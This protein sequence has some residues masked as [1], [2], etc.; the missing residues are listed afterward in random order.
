MLTT[1][2]SY[3]MHLLTHSERRAKPIVER[4]QCDICGA[5][6]VTHIITIY[7]YVVYLSLFSRVNRKSSLIVHMARHNEKPIACTICGKNLLNRDS[8]RM[9]NLR[10]HSEKKHSCIVC[11]KIFIQL[12]TLKVSVFYLV[13]LMFCE[14][15]AVFFMFFQDHMSLHTGQPQHKCPYCAKEF[16]SNSN[17]CSH[18]KKMHPIEWLE[19]RMQKRTEIIGIEAKN[20]NI[21]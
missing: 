15:I 9:H 13:F 14:L 7:Q 20:Q 16:N 12:Q 8:L 4:L 19:E 17:M 1:K 2:A 21:L 11:G 6:Y 10:L 18:R 5:W 3:D